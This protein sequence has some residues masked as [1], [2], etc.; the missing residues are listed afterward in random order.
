MKTI[1]IL[2]SIGGGG[3][4]TINQS[5]HQM[6]SGDYAVKSELYFSQVIN[7]VDPFSLATFG[8]FTG[9]DF[10][11]YVQKKR[12]FKF[13][14]SCYKASRWY[15]SLFAPLLIKQTIE[16]LEKQK[17]DLVISII[18]IVDDIIVKSCQHL[19]IPII[20][21]P[22]DL[23]ISFYT[24]ELTPPCYEKLY[25]ALPFD[26]PMS[27]EAMQAEYV[28]T[29]NIIAVKYPLRKD[30]YEPKDIPSLKKEWRVDD[31]RPVILL[32]MG[33]QGN[34]GSYTFAKELAK[35]S[36][37]AHVFICIGRNEAIR[38]KLEK[39]QFPRHI[40]PHIIGYTNH[41]AD[42][43]AI[44]DL[45]ISKT[46]AI[47]V[48]EAF[49]SKLPIIADQTE[50]MLSWEYFHQLFLQKYGCGLILKRVDNLVPFVQNLLNDP[51]LLHGIKKNITQMHNKKEIEVKDL[52]ANILKANE[53]K[54]NAP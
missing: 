4:T 8:N 51:T 26:N 46:G 47:T 12:C 24:Q 13:M 27:R 37:P 49:Q 34:I 38:R 15:Y 14:Q 36:K 11:N 39:I 23:D 6:L 30:F 31:G 7:S 43:M 48:M 25:L 2:T 41:V 35:L 45:L 28:Q 19:N 16:Y 44:A 52:V 42:L 20:I 32:M 1:L 18:P 54:K 53:S 3:Q 29:E 5:L 17:P 40:T 21:L 22:P 33:A 10:Y 50:F 9:E